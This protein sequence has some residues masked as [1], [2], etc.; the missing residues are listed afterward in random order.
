MDAILDL[1]QPWAYVLVFALAFTEGGALLGLFLPGE[2]AMILGGVLVGEGRADMAP[3]MIVAAGGSV[4]GDSV[5]YWI[6]RR[7][8]RRLRTTPLGLKVGEERWARADLALHKRGR[9]VV[10]FGRFLSILRS[11]VPPAAGMAHMPYRTFVVYNAPAAV[12]WAVG[13]VLLGVVADESWH[14]VEKWA[15]RGGMILL[16]IVAVVATGLYLRARS[17]KKNEE[18]DRELEVRL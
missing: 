15:G 9:S 18:L 4:I 5:G 1:S 6:G 7:Y 13:F 8:G 2:T 14:L 3:M 16:T 10:F 17:R 12:I 11:L